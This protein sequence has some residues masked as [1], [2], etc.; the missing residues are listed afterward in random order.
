MDFDFPTLLVAATFITGVIWALDAWLWAPKRHAAATDLKAAGAGT[1][2]ERIEAALKEPVLVEY[3]KSFFPVI[4]AVL[5]LRSFLVEPFRIPSGSMMPT[6]LVGD[7]ILVNK[8]TYGIRLPVAN[9]KVIDLNLPQRGDVAVFRYPK[10][11][12]VD[13]IKRVVGVPGDHIEYRDKVLY[14]NGAKVAQV[15]AGTYIGT[16]SG[17]SASG[18]SVRVE[19][20]GEVQHQILVEPRKP[21]RAG[22]FRVPEGEY[23]VM[24]DNRDNS[25]DSRFWG[26]VPE[27]NLV[28]K[29]FMI[30]M[31]WDGAGGGVSWQRIGEGIQ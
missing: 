10:D 29:A 2:A 12:S 19:Q 20:L 8:Y 21:N 6:L 18:A 1:N 11:P 7:F 17:L 3:A 9:W 23:F 26:T 24:G 14:V 25:N 13:Y 5:L 4:L 27:A 30:W 28:G 31:N 22:S 16:G 15:P